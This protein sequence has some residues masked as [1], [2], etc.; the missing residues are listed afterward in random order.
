MKLTDTF[1]TKLGVAVAGALYITLCLKLGEPPNGSASAAT[2]E[3]VLA[4]VVLLAT[5]AALAGLSESGSKISIPFFVVG[6]AIGVLVDALTDRKN[7]RNLFPIEMVFW[8]AF[9]AMAMGFGK[10][11]GE[12]W[13]KKRQKVAG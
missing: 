10:E 9:F 2:I 4:F 3:L 11:L 6:T 7:D 1:W 12:W 8:S 5:V 13:R